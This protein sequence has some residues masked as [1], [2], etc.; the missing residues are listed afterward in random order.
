[1]TRQKLKDDLI[2]NEDQKALEKKKKEIN[3]HAVM[4]NFE[5]NIPDFKALIVDELKHHQE[6]FA[7]QFKGMSIMSIAKKTMKELKL[8]VKDISLTDH[9]LLINSCLIGKKS[10]KVL[11]RA[12]QI[13]QP[14]DFN[15]LEVTVCSLDKSNPTY[16]GVNQQ[17]KVNMSNL[18]IKFQP[19]SI[20]ELLKF[21]RNTKP[22]CSY[23]LISDK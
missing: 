14:L 10:L 1:L 6:W 8:E 19:N 3:H 4:T 17:I 5:F 7:L 9:T 21:V 15:S 16:I 20:N 22:G 23:N 2:D 18:S 11:N 12:T 13:V